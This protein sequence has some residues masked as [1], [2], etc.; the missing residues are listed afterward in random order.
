MKQFLSWSILLSFMIIF[1]SCDEN[2]YTEQVIGNW[3]TVDWHLKG[4][5]VK[6][7]QKMDFVFYPEK[8][9]KVD[10]GTE[11]EEGKYWFEGM[12]LYSI[13]DGANMKKVKLVKLTTDTMML[14]MNRAGR[15]EEVLLVRIPNQ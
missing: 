9:Y 8:R 15:I 1:N 14:E 11:T 7:N 10:Y 2:P 5:P 3:R 4:S 6:I 12:D 13:E